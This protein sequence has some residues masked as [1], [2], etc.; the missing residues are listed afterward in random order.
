M[1]IYA[2]KSK[3]KLACNYLNA[4]NDLSFKM[5]RVFET[6]GCLLSTNYNE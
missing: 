5:K 6:Q 1:Q 2:N 3:F 4:T